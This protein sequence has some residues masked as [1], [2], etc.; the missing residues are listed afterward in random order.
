MEGE[1]L[2]DFVTWTVVW[3]TIRK[4]TLLGRSALLRQVLTLFGHLPLYVAAY[5]STVG[6]HCWR[7]DNARQWNLE[8][9]LWLVHWAIVCTGLLDHKCLAILITSYHTSKPSMQLQRLILSVL[10]CGGITTFTGTSCLTWCTT[11]WSG[12]KTTFV[13]PK[14]YA[15]AALCTCSSCTIFCLCSHFL[16]RSYFLFPFPFSVPFPVSP[17]YLHLI[18]CSLLFQFPQVCKW[19]NRTVCSFQTMNTCSSRNGEFNYSV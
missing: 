14:V 19:C 9:T 16:F 12:N 7:S 5:H 2:W 18:S 3:C 4:A 1:G 6:A 17:A 11:W 15:H 10:A 13:Q 8:V